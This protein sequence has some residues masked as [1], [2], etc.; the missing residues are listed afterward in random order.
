[1]TNLGH[2]YVLENYERKEIEELEAKTE[3]KNE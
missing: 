2:V 1:M 3:E